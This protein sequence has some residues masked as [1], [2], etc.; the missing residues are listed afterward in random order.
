[1]SSINIVWFKRD[2]RLHD[3]EALV[4]ATNTEGVTLLLYIF[5]PSVMQH[6][7]SDIRHQRFIYESLL[8]INN[9]LK[10]NDLEILIC[11]NEAEFV[12]EK[13]QENYTINTVFSYEEI[14]INLTYDR[15]KRLKKWFEKH[16]IPLSR[17]E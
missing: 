16:N 3:H 4:R 8:D 1:M 13:L 11:H 17:F 6:Y 10:I 14:G 5:E 15:D 9:R 7:D 12:F 2:L